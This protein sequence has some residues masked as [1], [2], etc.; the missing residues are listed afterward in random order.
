MCIETAMIL[1]TV[2]TNFKNAIQ[3]HVLGANVVSKSTSTGK[4]S[5]TEKAFTKAFDSGRVHHRAITH[6]I[7]LFHHDFLE[8]LSAVP[9]DIEGHQAVQH[10]MCVESDHRRARHNAKPVLD[11]IDHRVVDNEC[12]MRLQYASLRH[13]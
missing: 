4:C 13:S 12:A 3:K 5:R 8:R 2:H 7:V 10:A 6:S 1:Q 11:W 9:R